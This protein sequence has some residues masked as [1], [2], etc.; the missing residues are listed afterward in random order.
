MS[1]QRDLSQ[2]SRIRRPLGFSPLRLRHTAQTAG[3]TMFQHDCE[4]YRHPA[5]RMFVSVPD[6]IRLGSLDSNQD[7]TA[8]KAGVVPLDH[9]PVDRVL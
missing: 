3:V 6:R 5:E 1:E 9:S 8:P 2:Q 7:L 4:Q